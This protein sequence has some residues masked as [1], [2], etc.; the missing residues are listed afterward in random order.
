MFDQSEPLLS[1]PK[2]LWC[3]NRRWKEANKL[4]F[5]PD[6]RFGVLKI[7]GLNSWWR[8]SFNC[9]YPQMRK[10]DWGGRWERWGGVILC[11]GFCWSCLS[12]LS[13]LIFPGT[14]IPSSGTQ[15]YTSESF[16]IFLNQTTVKNQSGS[17]FCFLL[18]ILF[19]IYAWFYTQRLPW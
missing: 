11:P 7:Q 2:L 5:L 14:V 19:W 18:F 1:L 6:P 12:S 15:L 4:N 17:Y 13:Y 8:S 9:L 10:S 3:N 16:H